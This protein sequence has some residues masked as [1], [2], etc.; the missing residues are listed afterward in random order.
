MN[1]SKTCS[2]KSK[3]KILLNLMINDCIMIGYMNDVRFTISNIKRKS[4]A[5]LAKTQEDF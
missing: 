4:N 3:G 2:T 1:N 5:V